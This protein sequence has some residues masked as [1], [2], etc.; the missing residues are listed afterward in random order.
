MSSPRVVKIPTKKQISQ[1]TPK[2]PSKGYKN[3]FLH[4]NSVTKQQIQE[5]SSNIMKKQDLN[6]KLANSKLNSPTK[7]KIYKFPATE[8]QSQEDKNREF[9]IGRDKSNIR[10]QSTKRDRKGSQPKKLLISSAS[11]RDQLPHVVINGKKLILSTK[12]KK[13]KKFPK[14]LRNSSG[15]IKMAI[16]KSTNLLAP[17]KA[18]ERYKI[19]MNGQSIN[20]SILSF[21][22]PIEKLDLSKSQN[23]DLGIDSFSKSGYLSRS[24]YSKRSGKSKK[25]RASKRSS[26]NKKKRKRKSSSRNKTKNPKHHLLLGDNLNP[27]QMISPLTKINKLMPKALNQ[28]LLKQSQSPPPKPHLKKQNSSSTKFLEIPTSQYNHCKKRNSDILSGK[29]RQSRINSQIDISSQKSSQSRCNLKVGSKL[30]DQEKE[31]NSNEG[32]ISSNLSGTEII[33]NHRIVQRSEIMINPSQLNINSSIPS[34]KLSN[35]S[36]SQQMFSF[37]Q[38]KMMNQSDKF[39]QDFQSARMIIKNKIYQRQMS[40]TPNQPNS[41]KILKGHEKSYKGQKSMKCMR[42]DH[43]SQQLQQIKKS[44]NFHSIRKDHKN[45]T[46]EGG[47]ISPID[48]AGDIVRIFDITDGFEDDTLEKNGPQLQKIMELSDTESRPVSVEKRNESRRMKVGRSK[49]NNNFHRSSSYNTISS[50][51]RNRFTRKETITSDHT[52]KTTRKYSSRFYKNQS[53][54]K[55]QDLS[56][57]ESKDS[58]RS[59]RSG[60]KDREVASP[61]T[62]LTVKR[63]KIRKSQEK[64]SKVRKNQ[65]INRM[66]YMKSPHF[67]QNVN[68]YQQSMNAYLEIHMVEENNFDYFMYRYTDDQDQYYGPKTQKR[69]LFHH[70]R[71]KSLNLLSENDLTKLDMI[72]RKDTE[73]RVKK[74]KL[75]EQ[76]SE[77]EKNFCFG[78]MFK[79]F[80]NQKKKKYKDF[81]RKKYPHETIS[82]SIFGKNFELELMKARIQFEYSILSNFSSE[83]EEALDPNFTLLGGLEVID[84]D[85]VSAGDSLG[86]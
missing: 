68:N 12:L 63:R 44:F 82:K 56:V 11:K 8:D 61:L 39:I 77:Q 73:Q 60:F 50:G 38:K 42:E 19:Q 22:D 72:N 41:F 16:S 53:P 52:S 69:K 51:G 62:A 15:P 75:K 30:D 31:F 10:P 64:S 9:R 86:E 54:E 65:R 2:L 43:R 55:Y 66:A 70:I 37:G 25:S 5:K 84:G 20:K 46:S 83:K 17:F 21:R 81:R 78:S 85:K 14:N 80:I 57:S 29:S 32:T 49:T 24:R 47:F 26:K 74:N 34:R 6:L 76:E 71:L 18:G 36:L 35:E 27:N 67:Y 59:R 48:R 28:P 1:L 13:K 33:S 23:I 4:K 58:R 7:V 3:M 79:S 45:N 40:Q